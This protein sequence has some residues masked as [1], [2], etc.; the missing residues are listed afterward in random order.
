MEMGVGEK[1]F[2]LAAL[3]TLDSLLHQRV[4][5]FLVELVADN[6]PNSR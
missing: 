4:R 3:L 2:L 6:A 5:T 1:T